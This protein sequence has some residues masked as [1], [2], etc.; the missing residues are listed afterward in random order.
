MYGIFRDLQAKRDE[1]R[2]C[3]GA[4]DGGQQPLTQE[5]LKTQGAQ[6]RDRGEESSRGNYE[7]H[8]LHEWGRREDGGEQP[9]TQETLEAQGAQALE[10]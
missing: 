3:V 1:Q 9:S 10:F 6:T 4:G 7:S 8:E 5:T 2:K